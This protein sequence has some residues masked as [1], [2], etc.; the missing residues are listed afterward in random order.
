MGRNKATLPLPGGMQTTFVAHLAALLLPLCSEVIIVARDREQAA[1]Y[2]AHVPSS[3]SLTTDRVPDTGPLEGL[4]SG[5]MAMHA[6]RAFV[7]AVDMPLLQPAVVSY[8][9]DLAQ[10]AAD[11]TLLIPLVH[12]L[13]Q[14]LHA[15]YPRA[16]IPVIEERLRSGRRDPRSILQLAPVTYVGEE[17]LR[18]VDAE[19]HSFINVNTPEEFAALS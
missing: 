4:Y 8:L 10:G 11:D 14:V 17:Q 2:A 15:V 13:P 18:L 12:D 9:L 16:V 6:N 1:A 5:M 19:L 7:A 3:V